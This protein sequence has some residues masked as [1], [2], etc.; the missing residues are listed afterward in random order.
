MAL[1]SI[2]GASGKLGRSRSD[3]GE[4]HRSEFGGVRGVTALA[5]ALVAAVL[6]T[7]FALVALERR[8]GV[9][10][11]SGGESPEQQRNVSWF[12]APAPYRPTYV[13]W[14]RAGERP[15]GPAGGESGS[16]DEPDRVLYWVDDPQ[17]FQREHPSYMGAVLAVSTLAELDTEPGQEE[18]PTIEVRGHRGELV[19]VGDPGI[20]GVT[21]IWRERPGR[22]GAYSVGFPMTR[23]LLP[24]LAEEQMEGDEADIAGVI[25]AELI[26]VVESLVR[27][28]ES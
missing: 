8:P 26:R 2:I 16:I 27:R 28:G 12:C 3:L 20:G 18:F 9:L 19:W 24:Y 7:A 23:G 21:I 14:A 11:G 4:R 22:C 25:E 17:A 13:P 15:E 6:I 10:P 1:W 5:L